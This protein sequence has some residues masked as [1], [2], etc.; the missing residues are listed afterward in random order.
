M[1]PLE[2]REIEE[3][4]RLARL[5]L[6]DDE[7]ERLRVELAAILG[8][9]ESLRALDATGI[10][11]MTHAVPMQLRTRTDEVAPALSVGDSVGQAPD[12]QDGLFR[13]PHVIKTAS[14]ESAG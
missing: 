5:A 6:G 11:P 4:A 10:E 7:I 9:M 14:G 3:I 13:V 8:H 2:R 1:E 12:R